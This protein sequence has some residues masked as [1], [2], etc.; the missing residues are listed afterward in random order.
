MSGALADMK[1]DRAVRGGRLSGTVPTPQ[2]G[3]R[4]T[5]AAHEEEARPNDRPDPHVCVPNT[6]IT[7][8]QKDVA[9]RVHADVFGRPAVRGGER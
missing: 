1:T 5:A 2:D 4:V 7:I 8:Q 9:S 3:E 6:E